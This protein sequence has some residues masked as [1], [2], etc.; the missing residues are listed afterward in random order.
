MG[1]NWYQVEKTKVKSEDFSILPIHKTF[2]PTKPGVN[3]RRG[4]FRDI[5]H[6]VTHF[7]WDS[8][9]PSF[10]QGWTREETLTNHSDFNKYA[11]AGIRRHHVEGWNTDKYL[12]TG[13]AHPRH[14]HFDHLDTYV[15]GEHE[16]HEEYHLENMN[17]VFSYKIP[18]TI[19]QYLS[20]KGEA[21][22]PLARR[23]EYELQHAKEALPI[24]EIDMGQENSTYITARYTIPVEDLPKLGKKELIFTD[25][26][27]KNRISELSNVETLTAYLDKRMGVG[28]Q[29]SFL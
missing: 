9:F 10:W 20:E 7:L 23:L 25:D 1:H 11:S 6:A 21:R 24:T 26:K 15:K 2:Y 28:I 17:L 19:V 3:E 4:Q 14:P 13:P 22:G 16:N 12:E 5:G 8:S 18:E 29:S 27:L